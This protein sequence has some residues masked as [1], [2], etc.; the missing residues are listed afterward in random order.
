[1]NEENSSN[2]EI[3]KEEYIKNQTLITKY[4]EE[5]DKLKSA[6]LSLK[7]TNYVLAKELKE[8]NKLITTQ[9]KNIYNV[10]SFLFTLSEIL[11]CSS[12]DEIPSKIKNLLNIQSSLQEQNAFISKLKSLYITTKGLNP[13]DTIDIKEIWQ[14][15]KTIVSKINIYLKEK[16]L[17]DQ[18][19]YELICNKLMNKL[20]FTSFSELYSYI[21]QL[22]VLEEFNK[23]K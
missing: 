11:H 21:Q 20:N 16:E 2:Y 22:L 10:R 18:Y 4:K 14:W 13:N 6:N 9:Y 5:L 7:Y 23:N 19:Q 8:K 1:M 17:Q 3:N 12:Y 15:I